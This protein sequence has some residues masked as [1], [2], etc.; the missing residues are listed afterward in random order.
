MTICPCDPAAAPAIVF[1]TTSLPLGRKS[2]V[3]WTVVVKVAFCA[4]MSLWASLTLGVLP[5]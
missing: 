4:R 2:A 3:A 5:S 1:F